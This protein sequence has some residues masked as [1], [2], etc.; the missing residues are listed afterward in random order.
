MSRA[1]LIKKLEVLIADPGATPGEREAARARLVAI[2]NNLKHM[3]DAELFDI[4]NISRCRWFD[5]APG[6]HDFN[7][8]A[9]SR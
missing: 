8:L 5:S 6:H 7:H 3:S 1:E 9:T 2:K 4:T